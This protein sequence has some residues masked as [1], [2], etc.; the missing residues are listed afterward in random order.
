MSKKCVLVLIVFG[1]LFCTYSVSH[2]AE[3]IKLKFANFFPPTH[4][5]AQTDRGSFRAEA[6]TSRGVDPRR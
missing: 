2:G 3:A 5:N 6:P 1:L 4:K